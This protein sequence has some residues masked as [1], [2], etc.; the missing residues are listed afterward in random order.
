MDYAVADEDAIVDGGG[1]SDAE[2]PLE[3][4]KTKAS[5][6][7]SPP[8]SLLFNSQAIDS[9]KPNYDGSLSVN[10]FVGASKVESDQQYNLRRS[11]I[12]SS[13]Q[14]NQETGDGENRKSAATDDYDGTTPPSDNFSDPAP[15]TT[16]GVGSDEL[17]GEEGEV[18]EDPS[19]I[20][21]SRRRR[22]NHHQRINNE[23]TKKEDLRPWKPLPQLM[24]R[25]RVSGECGWWRKAE[26]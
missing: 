15:L 25:E 21:K 6:G 2:E 10:Q 11:T 24:A 9:D 3:L 18:E 22:N 4:V 20:V 26:A 19:Q 13:G 8:L 1:D 23:D 5:G 12:K 14:I 16:V 7:L 17:V